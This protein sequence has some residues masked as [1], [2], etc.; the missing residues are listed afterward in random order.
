[1]S[2]MNIAM[3]LVLKGSSKHELIYAKHHLVFLNMLVTKYNITSFLFIPSTKD[4][5]FS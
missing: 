5:F 1:M 3:R 2:F 4:N